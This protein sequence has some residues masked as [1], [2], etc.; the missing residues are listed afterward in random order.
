MGTTIWLTG[1]SG[2]GKTTIAKE[3]KKSGAY[4]FIIIDGD[5]LRAGINKNL[6][7][8]NEDRNENVFRAAH[9]CKILNDNG[10]NVIACIMS[11]TEEQRTIAKNVIGEDKF[12]LTYVQCNIE[13]LVRRDTKGLYKKF[14][15]GEIKN[16]VGCDLPYEEPHNENLCIDTRTTMVEACSLK[17]IEKWLEF[18][19]K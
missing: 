18:R 4:N 10:L 16:M 19:F 1:L 3:M 14:A 11:P 8:S 2:A 9:I 7:F 17:V 15:N 12:F 13:T 6:G 5:D